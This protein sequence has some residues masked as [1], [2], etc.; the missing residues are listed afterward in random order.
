MS[1]QAQET[2]IILPLYDE[3]SLADQEY[4]AE[5]LRAAVLAHTPCEVSA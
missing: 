5:Q 2:A 3:L 4:V 1:E